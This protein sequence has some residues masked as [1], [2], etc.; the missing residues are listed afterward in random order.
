MFEAYCT[1]CGNGFVVGPKAEAIIA[2][3]QGKAMGYCAIVRKRVAMLSEIYHTR[4]RVAM[5]NEIYHDTL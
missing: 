3:A 4:E 5:L 2:E 1:G